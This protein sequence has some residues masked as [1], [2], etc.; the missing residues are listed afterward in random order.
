MKTFSYFCTVNCAKIGGARCK[1]TNI[2]CVSLAGT[3][4][5]MILGWKGMK[6]AKTVLLIVLVALMMVSCRAAEYCNCG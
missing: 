5:A 4:F 3:I 6:T 1:T 2:V